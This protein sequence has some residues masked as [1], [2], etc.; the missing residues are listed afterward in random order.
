VA[1]ISRQKHDEALRELLLQLAIAD[2]IALGAAS[3]VGYRTARAAL[4]PVEAYRRAAAR[5]GAEEFGRLPVADDRDDEL[6]RLGHTLNDL[7]ARIESGA[8]R[9]RQFLADASHELR[10]P[11]AL[12][13]A[14]LEW[15]GHRPR[16][17]EEMNAVVGSLR[18]QLDRLVELT[19]ALLELEEMRAVGPLHRDEVRLRDLVADAVRD[20]L[21]RDHD[22]HIEVPDVTVRVNSR[23]LTVAVANLLRNAVRH[24]GGQITLA[25]TY[26][27]PALRLVVRDAGPGFPEDFRRTAFDRFTRA[28]TSRTTPGSGLGLYLVQSVAVAHAGS[29]RILQGPGAAIEMVVDAR[30][31]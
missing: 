10:T 2:L 21:P 22:L 9:E 4:D 23:W 6:S 16:T 17:A 24:G 15:A 27:E 13:S 19:N 8:A 18:G 11:M 25:A 28:E 12:M 14:E 20:A 31:T 29:T 30:G 3:F 5:A 26:D 1:A 7:L